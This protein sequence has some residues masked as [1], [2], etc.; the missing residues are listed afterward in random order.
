[1]NLEVRKTGKREDVITLTPS[2]REQ[3][4]EILLRRANEIAAF[5]GDYQRGNKDHLGSVE[6]ALT[7]EIQRLR[8]LAE[9]VNPPPL[10]DP[11]G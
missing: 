10:E 9:C 3:I 8:S 2:Q 1:M 5:S 7:R 4:S 6:L 11:A